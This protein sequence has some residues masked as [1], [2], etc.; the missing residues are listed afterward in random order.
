MKDFVKSVHWELKIL[1]NLFASNVFLEK[2]R[3]VEMEEKGKRGLAGRM[4]GEPP[5]CF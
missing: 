2:D 1:R 4:P 3:D 5:L